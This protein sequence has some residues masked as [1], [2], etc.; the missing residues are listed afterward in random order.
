M[1]TSVVYRRHLT[2]ILLLGTMVVFMVRL[3]AQEIAVK[4]NGLY[5]LTTTLN[6]GVEFAT[7]NKVT[8][9]LNAAYNPWTFK[10][11]KKMRFWL[12]QP[13]LKYWLCEKF[14]GHFVGLHLHGAQFF[15]GFKDKRYDGYLA[16]GGISYGYNWILSPHWNLEA[17]IGLGYARLWFKESDRIYCEK[18]YE[19]K[20]KNYVGPT[21]AAISLVY[22][23]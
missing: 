2:R 19:N 16:G 14:E 18:C 21:Q 10:D 4:M 15:G 3:S 20:T 12:A 7:S 9:E 1:V 5:W 17:A 23:F 22:M 11:D 8:I 6:A 13:E